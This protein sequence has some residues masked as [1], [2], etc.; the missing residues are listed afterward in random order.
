MIIV[1]LHDI[2]TNEFFLNYERKDRTLEVSDGLTAT[3]WPTM[4]T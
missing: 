2:V 4:A 1:V 3:R